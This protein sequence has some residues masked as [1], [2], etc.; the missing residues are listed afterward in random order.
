[1]TPR[2]LSVCSSRL[3]QPLRSELHIQLRT[4]DGDFFDSLGHVGQGVS[5]MIAECLTSLA[6]FLFQLFSNYADNY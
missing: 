4:R 3:D 5:D 1:M 2:S 6:D